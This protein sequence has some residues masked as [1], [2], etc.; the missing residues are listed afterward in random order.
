M[1]NA[2]C[3]PK[4]DLE[5]LPEADALSEKIIDNLEAVRSSFWGALSALPKSLWVVRSFTK[6]A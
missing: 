4:A 5:N 6:K 1:R 2:Y 3:R